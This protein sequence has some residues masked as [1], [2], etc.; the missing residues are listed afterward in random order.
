[1]SF[2]IIRPVTD[3]AQKIRILLAEDHTVTRLG[4]RFILESKEALEL[5]GEAVNGADAVNKVRQLN[6]DVVIMDV[7][8]PVMDG[9]AAAAAIRAEH[10]GMKIVML[11]AHKDD[12]DIFGALAAGANGY[13]VKDITDERLLHAIESVYA[14]DL[15]LDSTI[16]AKVV[17][18]LPDLKQASAATPEQLSER[19]LQV[20][21]LI[22]DGL[23]NQQIAQKLYISN[24]TV[25]T[26]IKRILEKLSASDRT[27]AAVKALRQG[28]V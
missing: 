6:P 26:H 27:Q 25:K 17:R 12:Q 16:A 3:Q 7:E 23:S 10:P 28:L 14:G 18:A 20:L 13:C 2:E 11:T 15:W 5:V 24:D 22:V 8:M 19:E 9:I 21:Q 4:L 1:M